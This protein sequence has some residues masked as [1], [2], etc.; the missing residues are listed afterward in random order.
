MEL[1]RLLNFNQTVSCRAYLIV[2]AEKAIHFR[3]RLKPLVRSA[4]ENE[5]GNGNLFDSANAEGLSYLDI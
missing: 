2:E 5:R 3:N 1:F 4:R